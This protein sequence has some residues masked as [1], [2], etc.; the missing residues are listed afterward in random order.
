[1]KDGENLRS[2]GFDVK[3]ILGL[4]VFEKRPILKL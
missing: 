1:M 3:Q 2:A 4:A